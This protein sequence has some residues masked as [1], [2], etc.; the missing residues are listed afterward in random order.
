[1]QR[2]LDG[3]NEIGNT[4]SPLTSSLTELKYDFEAVSVTEQQNTKLLTGPSTEQINN[5]PKVK[6]LSNHFSATKTAVGLRQLAKQI[7]NCILI[8]G[9]TKMRWPAHPQNVLLVSKINDN[10]L[11]T[12]TIDLACWL[13]DFGLTTYHTIDS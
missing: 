11:A 10:S 5:N 12:I 1:M 3:D 8:I 6:R 4:M 9:E 7:G 13:I 2:N